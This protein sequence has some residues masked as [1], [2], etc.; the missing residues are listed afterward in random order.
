MFG[1][2]IDIERLAHFG[3]KRLSRTPEILFDYQDGECDGLLVPKAKRFILPEHIAQNLQKA[4]ELSGPYEPRL[5]SNNWQEVLY[6]TTADNTAV[7]N[8]TTETPVIEAALVPTIPAKYCT[9]GKILKW[10]IWGRVSTV[11]T[12]PGTITFKRR[13]GGTAGTPPTGTTMVTSK[14]QRPKVTVSTNMAS[15]FEIITVFRGDIAVAAPSFTMGQCNMG[16]TIGDAQAAGENPWP[17]APAAV[18]VDTTVA[19]LDTPSITFSVAT[20][21]TSWQTHIGRLEALN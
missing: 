14:A 12:T 7:T 4:R 17:D 9:F 10:F 19:S 11:V 3:G 18:N 15:W 21:T 5:G 1:N 2:G 16:N 8:S 13:W 6:K 20:A